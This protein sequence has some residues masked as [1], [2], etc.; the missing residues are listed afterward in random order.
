M[1]GNTG[2]GDAMHHVSAQCLR[3]LSETEDLGK[4][5]KLRQLGCNFW[6]CLGADRDDFP[7][8]MTRVPIL[9]PGGDKG[10]RGGASEAH[11][12]MQFC[13]FPTRDSVSCEVGKFTTGTLGRAS[14]E[15]GRAGRGPSSGLQ[16]LTFAPTAPGIGP[17]GESDAGGAVDG[18]P[19]RP[20]PDRTISQTL[21]D[22]ED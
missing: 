21:P 13:D 4:P 6:R 5:D 17:G 15:D 20:S 1:I 7:R 12:S 18:L 2:V 9:I 14:E 22:R 16:V 11:D 19:G 8:D 10:L 3:G